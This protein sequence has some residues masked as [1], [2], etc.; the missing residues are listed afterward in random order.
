MCVCFN[1]CCVCVCVCVIMVCPS[2]TPA[3]S[4]GPTGLYKACCCVDLTSHR[5]ESCVRVCVCVCERLVGRGVFLSEG[6]RHVLNDVV[7]LAGV[8]KVFSVDV[9]VCGLRDSQVCRKC[10]AA[11]VVSWF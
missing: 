2:L 1:S 9:C 6:P 11:G 8:N 7:P 4:G 3:G 5:P 10:S